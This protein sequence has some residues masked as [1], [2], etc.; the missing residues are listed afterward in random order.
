MIFDIEIGFEVNDGLIVENMDLSHIHLAVCETVVDQAIKLR[1]TCI[2]K[3]Y[4]TPLWITLSI[5][6]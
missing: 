3:K 5:K 2:L 6:E 1:Y 4:L